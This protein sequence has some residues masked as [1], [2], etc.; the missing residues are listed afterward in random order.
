MP[1]PL[2]IVIAEDNYLLRE[3]VRRLLED[4]GEVV[5]AAAV[6]SAP[7]LLDAVGRLKPDAVLTDIRMPVPDQGVRASD[8][9]RHGGHPR[10]APDPRDTAGRG[11]V[12]LSQYAD[13]AYAFALVPRRDR[14]S[15]V[16]AQGP[17]R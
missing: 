15:G 8:R 11:V 9:A 6:G 2:R 17:R 10:G 7:E 4:S 5:V 16:P 12:I 13:E 3:G 1:E 14:G